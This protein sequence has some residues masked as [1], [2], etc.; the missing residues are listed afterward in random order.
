M[1]PGTTLTARMADVQHPDKNVRIEAALELGKL[2][3]VRAVPALLATRDARNSEL[4]RKTVYA[5]GATPSP[6]ARGHPGAELREP[7]KGDLELKS[8]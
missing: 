1:T 7:V 6:L 3:D 8:R 4:V 5:P 2:A